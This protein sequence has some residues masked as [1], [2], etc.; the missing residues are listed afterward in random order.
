MIQIVSTKHYFYGYVLEDKGEATETVSNDLSILRHGIIAQDLDA[1]W[2]FSKEEAQS[3]G[4]W[5]T[6]HWADSMDVIL[7]DT[8]CS[9]F[10][11]IGDKVNIYYPNASI[12]EA[13]MFVV[14]DKSTVFGANGLTTSVTVRRVR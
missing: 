12:D 1:S 6:D 3:L 2:I 9:T 13:W 14:T 4:K 5:I 8:F 11:Q 10:I 7:L